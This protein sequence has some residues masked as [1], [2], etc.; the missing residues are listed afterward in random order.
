MQFVALNKAIVKIQS[1][2]DIRSYLRAVAQDPQNETI[3]YAKTK[4]A[5]E[6][7]GIGNPFTAR[8]TL[9]A[10]L[11]SIFFQLL[12][13]YENGTHEKTADTWLWE[14]H[15]HLNKMVAV[16]MVLEGNN[17]R[18]FGATPV[19]LDIP[20]SL[21]YL[22]TWIREKEHVFQHLKKNY[23]TMTMNSGSN[24]FYTLYT[25]QK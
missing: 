13:V 11:N 23:W 6:T 7:A 9:I 17:L 22:N 21:V 20:Q 18:S 3:D 25:G 16:A 14:N 15:T 19:R 1:N 2:T 5:V 12:A 24:E 10:N 4:Q 8:L